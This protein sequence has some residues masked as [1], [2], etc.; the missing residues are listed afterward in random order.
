MLESITDRQHSEQ[1][2]VSEFCVHAN[3]LAD[4]STDEQG[5]LSHPS[6]RPF[7]KMQGYKLDLK[8]QY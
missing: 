5:D 4:I 2:E 3:R 8:Q 6:D 1:L 7:N